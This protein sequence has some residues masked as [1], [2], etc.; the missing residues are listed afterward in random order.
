MSGSSGT[1]TCCL[2]SPPLLSVG[3]ERA[4]GAQL[5]PDRH[6]HVVAD[7]ADSVKFR[8]RLLRF[9]RGYRDPKMFGSVT[10]V[11]SDRCSCLLL[12]LG[13]LMLLLHMVKTCGANRVPPRL[14]R[15]GVRRAEYLRVDV[16][17]G[18]ERQSEGEAEVGEGRR[19]V[20]S[21]VRPARPQ[22]GGH[23]RRAVVD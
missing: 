11:R 17:Q 18:E 23:P 2:R 4:G 3:D 9:R 6:R 12:L 5:V 13:V 1:G 15:V 8:R 16:Q 21:G 14:G 22:V 20:P 10:V 19:G 7:H